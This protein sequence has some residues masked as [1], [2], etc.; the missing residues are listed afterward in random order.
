MTK[1]AAC[2]RSH[3]EPN[4]PDPNAQGQFSMSAVTTGGIDPRAPQLGQA[5][6]ACEKDLPKSGPT[7]VSPATQAQARQQLLQFSACMR[8]HGV[9]TFPDPPPGGQAIRILPGSGIDTQSPQYQAATAARRRYGPALGPSL[10]PLLRY[11][12]QVPMTRWCSAQ[13]SFQH[14]WRIAALRSICTRGGRSTH[15]RVSLRGS[16]LQRSRR[17]SACHSLPLCEL[18][19]GVRQHVHR[20]C[21]VARRGVRGKRRD[22]KL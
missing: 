5:V 14:R 6:Q 7:A 4:F 8:S 15:R 19:K 3:G 16:P 20:V 21:L 9:P 22:L 12:W 10:E 17:P 18:P 2:V 11:F 13:A 1:F